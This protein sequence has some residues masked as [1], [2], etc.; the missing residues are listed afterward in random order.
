MTQDTTKIIIEFTKP[1]D[2]NPGIVNLNIEGS[3]SLRY[4]K[5]IEIDPLIWQAY[6]EYLFID[7]YNCKHKLDLH[8]N[9]ALFALDTLITQKHKT[10][11]NITLFNH[12]RSTQLQS[13]LE[14]REDFTL[15]S[16]S[17]CYNELIK[18]EKAVRN[19]PSSRRF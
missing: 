19:N 15:V 13:I 16:L 2:G 6:L 1:V 3:K 12:K 9:Q 10:I 14:L 8:N 4:P 5:T 17:K 18:F 7:I 11:C